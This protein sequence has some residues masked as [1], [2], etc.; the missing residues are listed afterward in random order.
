M[1]RGARFTT[2][3]ILLIAVALTVV[4]LISIFFAAVQEPGSPVT[5]LHW[6]EHPHWE[7]FATACTVGGFASL[8]AS[9]GTVAVAVV[10]VGVLLATLGGYALSRF[11]FRG[12]S[13]VVALLLLG[14][15]L[16]LESIVLSLYYGMRSV[17]LLD[18]YWALILPLIGVF[19]PFGIFWMRA[20]F[21]S[22]PMELTEA[23]EMDGAG[24]Y[25]VF[26]RIL[27]PTAKPALATLALLYFMWSWNQ[28]LLALVLIQDPNRRTAPAGL[29]QFVTQYG[30][31][32][33][34]LSAS[35][36][37]V[38]VPVVIVYA[39]FQRQL[40]RGFLQGAVR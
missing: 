29:G 36:I 10:P 27:L 7:N 39:I 5:G 18:T 32:I 34:L 33:P 37:V 19:M 2:A 20:H 35:T 25:T 1:T 15:T 30:K 24:P 38:M 21:D 23:A 31:D 3:I 11:R 28:F 17:G 14:L 12:S 13:V 26:V 4:P 8:F 9:S 6:P 16:P 22:L 40:V